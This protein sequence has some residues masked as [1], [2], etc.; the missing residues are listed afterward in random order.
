MERAARWRSDAGDDRGGET[1]RGKGE[2]TGARWVSQRARRLCSA[3][4]VLTLFDL[5]HFCERRSVRVRAVHG[6]RLFGDGR[7]GRAAVLAGV[8]GRQGAQ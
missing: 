2:A 7:R 5:G 3:R 4:L 8:D 6:R 1:R